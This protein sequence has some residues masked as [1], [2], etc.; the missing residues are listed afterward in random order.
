[1]PDG[2][3]THKEAAARLGRTTKTLWQWRRDKY[4]PPFYRL[5]GDL[6]YR[7]EEIEKWLSDQ[8]ETP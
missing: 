5:G 1:M 3:I 4:G 6:L 8:K 7:P 2:Y